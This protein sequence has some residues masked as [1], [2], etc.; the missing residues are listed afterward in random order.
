MSNHMTGGTN[1]N[2]LNFNMLAN[3]KIPFPPNEKQNEIAQHIQSIRTKAKLL[4]A[5]A[6]NVLEKAKREVDG[7]QSFNET[8]RLMP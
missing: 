2:N 5:E 7:I 3:L 8:C 4:K 6:V 1:I